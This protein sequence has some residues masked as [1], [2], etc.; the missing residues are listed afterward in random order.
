MK[1]LLIICDL[2]PPAFGPRMGYLCKYL[3]GTG[4]EPFVLTEKIN[5]ST[6][7]LL[8]DVCP[9]R[10]LPYYPA[11]GG[12]AGRLVRMALLL[13]SVAGFKDFIFRREADRL[14]ARAGFDL[15]LC[16]TYR[17]FPLGV[18]AAA[19][20][21][22]GLPW[23]ADLRDIVEQ[24]TGLE[25]IATKLPQFVADKFTPQLRDRF[26]AARNRALQSASCVTTV[27]A[28]HVSTLR[29]YS[30]GICLIYNG[31]D[32][33]LFKP[34]TS[35]SDKFVITYTGRLLSR[36]M[37]DPSLL[38]AAIRML[39]A[40]NLLSPDTCRVDWY[41]D[42]DS[43]ADIDAAAQ[44]AGVRPYM[45]NKGYV[46][47]EQIPDVL[48]AS[49]VVLLLANKESATGPRGVVTTKVFE[50]MA[51]ERPILCVRSDESTIAALLA[52]SR[53]GTAASGPVEACNFLRLH[54][55]H[56]LRH[57]YTCVE[58]YRPFI[59]S[60]SRQKQAHEFARIF[61]EVVGR[62]DSLS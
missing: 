2:F 60:F 22:F 38:F 20:R 4:W 39:A 33:E 43:W 3:K 18:A 50:A 23:I 25:F 46:P 32:P 7:R 24:Y 26:I 9:V 62:D 48:A 21:K 31:Y 5:D 49:S 51:M 58:P 41:T 44:D 55:R 10:A 37:R 15:I 59:E 61:D 47:A 19:A 45:E 13:L 29:P 27:S 16:S 12:L 36:A 42:P 1:K 8:K 14:C 11:G 53:C 35:T 6:F 34:R 40:E 30:P 52:D 56:W 57:G 28:F 54:Y 17:S